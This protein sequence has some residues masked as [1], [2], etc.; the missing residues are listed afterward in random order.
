MAY[1]CPL[2]ANTHTHTHTHIHTYTHTHTHI[3][4]NKTPKHKTHKRPCT[5][6]AKTKK[7]KKVKDF[8]V[9][10][11]NGKPDELWC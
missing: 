5:I 2:S 3:H 1:P 4:T 10:K 6:N 8:N 9:K 7:I 11:S